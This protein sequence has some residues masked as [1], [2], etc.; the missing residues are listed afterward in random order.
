VHRERSAARSAIRLDLRARAGLTA[1]AG[2]GLLAFLYFGLRLLLDPER[3]YVGT[4]VDPQIFI[5]AFGWWPHAIV[6]GENPIVT[7]AVWAPDGVNLAWTTTVPGLALLFWPLTATVGA[8]AAYN[9]AAVAMPA[10]AAWTAF[11][12]CRHVTHRVWPALVGGYV[13]GFSGYVVGQE[14]GHLHMTA[15]FVVPLIALVLVRC[16]EGAWSRTGL[17]VRLAPLLALQLLM[18]TE[19]MFTLTLALAS[20]IV[21]AVILVPARRR[22]VLEAIPGVVAAYAAAAVLTAPYVYY[23]LTSFHRET[24]HPPQDF[25]TDLLNFVV[26]TRLALVSA[27]WAGSIAS[28]F[29]GNN[30]ERGAYLGVPVVL[31][32]ALYAWRGLRRPGGRF[33]V[34]ALVVAVLAALGSTLT[35]EGHRIAP[36]PWEH[37]GY[38][39]LFDN[40]L[41]IRL[42]LYVSLLVAVMTALWTAHTGSPLLRYVLPTLG[43]LALVPHVTGHYWTNAFTVPR[44]FTGGDYRTCL[45]PNE[46][47]LPLPVS[48]TGSANLWQVEA[49][50]RFRMAGGYVFSG[51]PDAFLSPPAVADIAHGNGV[52]PEQRGKLLAYIRDKHVTAVV[53]DSA[54]SDLWSAALD[55][56]ARPVERD[57]VIVYRIADRGRCAA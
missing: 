41:V 57:G 30:S 15:V 24:F 51:P 49:G 11:L 37:I 54:E 52:P 17:V 20:A 19:L 33:L 14:Q 7:H 47:I 48:F 3:E 46:N 21:L 28:H 5:W 1:L 2:Y 22:R 29:P 36:L 9:A 53:V 16:V 25:V 8:I 31:I 18:S 45:E 32:V 26:P 50:Y 39:P 23:L 4:G 27:G 35:V 43:V 6:H 10:L 12:L 55:T 40:V 34:A 38:L 56:I 44:F 13:F 42:T